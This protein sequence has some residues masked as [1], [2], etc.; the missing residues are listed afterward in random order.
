MWINNLHLDWKWV[1]SRIRQNRIYELYQYFIAKIK[2][3]IQ[4]WNRKNTI[5]L[6]MWLLSLNLLYYPGIITYL[7][8]L[9]PT[10]NYKIMSPL[11]KDIFESSGLFYTGILLWWRF[12]IGICGKILIKSLKCTWKKNKPKV[13]NIDWA[14]F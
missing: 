11:W 4:Q 3:L 13:M 7:F 1:F 5:H 10:P 2:S 6:H 8:H 9:I 12:K 14:Y